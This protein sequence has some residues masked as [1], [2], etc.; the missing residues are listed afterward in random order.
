[1]EK[2]QLKH[3]ENQSVAQASNLLQN[4][5]AI[6]FTVLASFCR[7]RALIYT[8][9]TKALLFVTPCLLIRCGFGV[10]M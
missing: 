1:M 2:Y 10:R 9:T 5:D 8:R 7:V 3:Y 6:T 4:E